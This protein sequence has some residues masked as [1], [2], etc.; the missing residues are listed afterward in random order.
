MNIRKLDLNKNHKK[1]GFGIILFFLLL[2]VVLVLGFMG[3]MV[4]VV[5]DITNDAL[6]PVM[7]DLGVVEG[8]DA[9]ISEYADY[10]FGVTNTFIASLPWLIAFGYVL[11]LVF[12]LVFVFLVGYTPHPAFMGLYFALMILLIFG[13]IIISNIYQDFYQGSTD[14]SV[15]L[16][17]QTIMSN[18]IL[19]SPFI[20]ALIGVIGGIL[21]FARQSQSEGGAVGGFGL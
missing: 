4:W 3:A 13:C 8:I 6:Y 15:R 1:G 17:E 7:Q 18:L 11:T 16:K 12:T 5:I 10:G 19:R 9:N 14:I 20:M 2:L 21:M